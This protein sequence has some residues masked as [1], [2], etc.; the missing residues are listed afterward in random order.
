MD[1]SF[2]YALLDPRDRWHKEAVMVM[3]NAMQCRGTLITT[4]FIVAETHALLLSRFGILRALQWLEWVEMV[5]WI[6]RALPQDE[7]RAKEI[8]R[9]YSDKDFSLT[10]AISFA[11]MERLKIQVALAVNKHFAEYGKFSILPLHGG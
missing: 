4:N 9:R 3:R 2:F 7:E 6:E 8:L 10:D 5:T 11:V 1:T